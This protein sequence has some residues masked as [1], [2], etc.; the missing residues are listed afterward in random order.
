[1]DSLQRGLFQSKSVM[2]KMIV[3][4]FITTHYSGPYVYS[5]V[6]ISNSEVGVDTVFINFTNYCHVWNT[7]IW[8][9]SCTN[10]NCQGVVLKK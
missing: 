6:I 1:M 4:I 3:I 8:C 2:D 10:I 9:S 5:V 7:I